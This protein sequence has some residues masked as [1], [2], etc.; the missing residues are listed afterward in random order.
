MASYK[1]ITTLKGLTL[2]QIKE[3]SKQD[4]K[5]YFRVKKYD[6]NKNCGIC[7]K[8]IQHIKLVTLDHIVPRSAGGRTRERNTRIA[9]AKCNSRRGDAPEYYPD[10]LLKQ[11]FTPMTKNTPRFV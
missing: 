5:H 6:Q 11:A 9:H 8:K 4:T 7:G 10:S 3:F 2:E 1:H